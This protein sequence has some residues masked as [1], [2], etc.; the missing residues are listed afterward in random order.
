MSCSVADLKLINGPL[1]LIQ[2]GLG[3]ELACANSKKIKQ[4]RMAKRQA[5]EKR[6]ASSLENNEQ[7]SISS[8]G[9]GAVDLKDK[10]A[11]M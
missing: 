2:L 3:D 4:R 9:A 5:K 1:N 10:E 8:A 7:S 11:R 6:V